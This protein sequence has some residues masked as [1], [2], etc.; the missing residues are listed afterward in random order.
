[1]KLTTAG[2]AA[3]MSIAVPGALFAQDATEPEQDGSVYSEAVTSTH[4]ASTE[5]ITAGS[6]EEKV[7]CKRDKVIGS[8]VKAERV[9]KTAQEWEWEKRSQRE[10]VERGQNQRTVSGQ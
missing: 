4:I 8:R 7:I 6:N 9:C 3:L 5:E 10:M 1:M 2:L